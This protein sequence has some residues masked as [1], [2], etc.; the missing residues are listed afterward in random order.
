MNVL[1]F[2][3]HTDD[4][5]ISAG[6]YLHR[7]ATEGH[8]VRVV[9][10]SPCVASIPE[11]FERDVTTLECRQALK[12][13]GVRDVTILDYAVRHFT[14]HRQAILDMMVQ[15]KK[16]FRPDLVLSPSA[17]DWHQDHAQV[18][19]EAQRAF[20]DIQRLMWESPRQTHATRHL[21]YARIDVNDLRA[22]L[23]ACECYVSQRARNPKPAVIDSLARLRGY[24]AGS[25]L[26]EA[27]EVSKWTI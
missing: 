16:D 10:L 23:S 17:N 24:Q 19:V 5:E 8:A 26:A 1:A 21:C 13:L 18:A 2:S 6:G 15:E 11:G 9:V 25:G 12:T 14:R 7:L 22:K 3:P 27:Y 20:H 4:A